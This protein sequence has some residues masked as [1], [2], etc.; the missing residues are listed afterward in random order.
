M[1]LSKLD[2]WRAKHT[3]SIQTVLQM[4]VSYPV[5]TANAFIH[6]VQVKDGIEDLRDANPAE[7]SSECIVPGD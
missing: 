4:V 6:T 3:F 5:Q 7:R 1:L 2:V